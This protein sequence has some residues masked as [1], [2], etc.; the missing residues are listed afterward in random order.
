MKKSSVLR[1]SL[2]LICGASALWALSCS[3]ESSVMKAITAEQQCVETRTWMD[4]PRSTVD[5]TRKTWEPTQ[6]ILVAQY[7]PSP[8]FD[9][10]STLK[11]RYASNGRII[12]YIGVEQP[13]QHDYRYDDHDNVTDFR[14]S[15]PDSVDVL[16]PSQAAPWMEASYAN[17]YGPSGLLTATTVTSSGG[18]AGPSPGR[19]TYTEDAA[20]RCASV[21]THGSQDVTETRTYD[22]AGRL[23]T[24][25]Q[26]GMSWPGLQT[27][28][29]DDQNRIATRSYTTTNAFHPGTTTST[30]TYGLD[31]S[32]TITIDDGITDVSSEQHVTVTRTAACLAIDAAI[33]APA[34]A[35]CRVE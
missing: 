1:Q 25:K 19:R 17:E 29:Y 18:G 5:Y 14:L 3:D 35:H 13:F 9:T 12:A 34:D 8:T 7:S 23:S 10:V 28:T 2:F 4:T 33:G 27:I 32:Q 30:F 22:Q 26:S 16:S 24:V 15:Y 6:R 20:G 21:E 31:G 11:W